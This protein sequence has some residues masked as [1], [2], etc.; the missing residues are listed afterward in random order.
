MNQATLFRQTGVG[1]MKKIVVIFSIIALIVVTLAG[2]ASSRRT[3]VVTASAYNSLPSQTTKKNPTLA[4][5]GDTLKPGMKAIAV[6]RDLLKMGMTRNTR[7]KIQGMKGT[8]RV[9]DKM[10]KRWRKKIDIYMGT[11]VKAA[12]RW[13][14]RKIKISWD[15]NQKRKRGKK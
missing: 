2:A 8:Y 12:R 7:V 3:M 5:W 13:G 1:H 4:A 9:L 11:N 10:N 14:R 15:P 6:S